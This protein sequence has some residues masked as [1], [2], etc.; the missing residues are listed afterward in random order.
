MKCAMVSWKLG[1]GRTKAGDSINH[2]V[3]LELT[4]AVGR[5]VRKGKVT[6]VAHLCLAS[7]K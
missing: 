5:R 3:G 1:A 6:I 2:A 7:H 4:T